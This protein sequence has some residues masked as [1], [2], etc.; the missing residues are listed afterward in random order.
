MSRTRQFLS[1]LGA[2]Y[3]QLAI[4]SVCG[5]WLTRFLLNR[6]GREDYG[7]WLIVLQL[8][9]FLELLDLGV[10]AL[11]PREVGYLT[12]S[13]PEPALLLDALGQLLARVRRLL[14]WQWPVVAVGAIGGWWWLVDRDHPA[15]GPL[16]LVATT[17]ALLFPAR[18]CA[19]L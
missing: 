11:V 13:Q 16:A 10:V 15:A 19:G 1:G 2:N 9:A 12:G 18:L 7:V 3:F 5:L 6:V 14:L 4:V 17:Y 8:L